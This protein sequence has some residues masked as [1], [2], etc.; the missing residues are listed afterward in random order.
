MSD[1]T[2]TTATT[3]T[4]TRTIVAATFATTDG[5]SRAAG[6]VSGAIPERIGNTAVVWIKP[7]GTPKFV[8]TKDW[9]AGRGGL[10]G[11]AIGL[12]AG[13]VGLLA[14]SALGILAA[15]LRDA[16]FNDA[17]L[18]RLGSTLGANDSAVVFDLAATAASTARD[19]LNSLGAVRVVT[20]DVE[21]DV[22]RLFTPATV[23]SD[24]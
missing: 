4:P 19:V 10:V 7:D 1:T 3:S 6:A 23:G 13:P 24:E 9:G 17:Q 5:A 16:G 14:G 21:A 22:A 15:R 20:A 18:A 8:E 11:G 2:S 12:L